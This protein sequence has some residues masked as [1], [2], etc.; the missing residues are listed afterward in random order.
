MVLML[1]TLLLTFSIMSKTFFN[2][3]A[4]ILLASKKI[5]DFVLNSFPV[6]F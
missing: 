2:R 1:I 3:M 6:V 5:L 4:A